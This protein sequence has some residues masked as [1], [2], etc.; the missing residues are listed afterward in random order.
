ME[1]NL[2]QG[3]NIQGWMQPDELQFLYEQAGKS[4]SVLE[5]GSWK[6]RSSHALL[7]GCKGMVTC[8]DTFAGSAQLG[9]ATNAMAKQEDI[10][11]QFMENVGH[12]TNLR[13]IKATSK[14]AS[15]ILKDEKFDLI[16]IDGGHQYHEVKEDIAL[17]LPHAKIIMCGHDYTGSWHDVIQAVFESLRGN[18]D[19]VCDSIWFK[20]IKKDI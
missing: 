20:K 17:W 6:G 3:N 15:E 1:N 13:V 12:F 5:I 18:P 11:K 9:D 7:S 16:F 8:V 4:K 10:Y 14:E 19:G 2:Y